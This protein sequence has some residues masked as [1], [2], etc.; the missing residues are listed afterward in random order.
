MRFTVYADSLE[1]RYVASNRPLM[2]QIAES[3]G[4]EELSLDRWNELPRLVTDFELS[5]RQE[6]KPEDAWD[7]RSFFFALMALLALEWFVRRRAG[8]V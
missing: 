6:T 5:T 7:T 1:T 4:G 2:A 3:S 8:L